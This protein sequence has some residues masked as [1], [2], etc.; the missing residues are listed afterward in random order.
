MTG[1]LESAYF[2]RLDRVSFFIISLVTTVAFA[3][4]SLWTLYSSGHAGPVIEAVRGGQ[5]ITL[6]AVMR[7]H[8]V[9][10]V[11]IGVMFILLGLFLISMTFFMAARARDIGLWGWVSAMVAWCILT[12]ALMND[13]WIASLSWLAAGFLLL[14]PSRVED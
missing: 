8:G 6:P 7:A 12:T 2:G 5:V 9:A 14:W 10:P 4:L 13:P 3:L 1:L 11:A